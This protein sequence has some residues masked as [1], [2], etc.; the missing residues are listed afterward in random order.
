MGTGQCGHPHEECN[1]S[2]RLFQ[3]A[4][5]DPSHYDPIAYLAKVPPLTFAENIAKYWKEKK[6]ICLLAERWGGGE[7]GRGGD[8]N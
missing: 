4:G 3:V 1:K 8:A 7:G 2:P 6:M 5:I